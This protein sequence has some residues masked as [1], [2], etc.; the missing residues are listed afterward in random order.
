MAMMVAKRNA[1]VTDPYTG[2]VRLKKD[3][4]FVSDEIPVEFAPLVM[5]DL[6]EALRQAGELEDGGL[7]FTPELWSRSLRI[8]EVSRSGILATKGAAEYA[9]DRFHDEREIRQRAERGLR[10]CGG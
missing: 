3:I 10:C 6:R 4:S 1:I 7:C 8:T 5:D 2:G 9:P